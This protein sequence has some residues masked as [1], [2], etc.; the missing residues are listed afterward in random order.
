MGNTIH[1]L[2]NMAWN[3]HRKKKTKKEERKQE[4]REKTRKKKNM[5]TYVQL[6]CRWKVNIITRTHSTYAL[7]PATLIIIKLKEKGN[8][9]FFEILTIGS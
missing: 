4:R 2:H 3:K 5:I 1:G 9:A 6:T 8:Y 7:S